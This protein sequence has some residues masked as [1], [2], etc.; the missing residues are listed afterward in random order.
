MTLKQAICLYPDRL[1]QGLKNVL[2]LIFTY[3]LS[4][5]EEPQKLQLKD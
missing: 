5:L 3:L 2:F 1:Y 4:G